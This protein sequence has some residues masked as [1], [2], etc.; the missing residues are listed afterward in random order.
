MNC[1][2]SA[3]LGVWAPLPS[4]Q[5]EFHYPSIFSTTTREILG[6]PASTSCP[7]VRDRLYWYS[8]WWI[9]LTQRAY[10]MNI[11]SQPCKIS[12]LGLCSF[13]LP[14][15]VPCR[16]ET[17]CRSIRHPSQADTL[18]PVARTWARFVARFL[19]DLSIME[20]S[21]RGRLTTLHR[22]YAAIEASY[23]PEAVRFYANA[24]PYRH[25][26]LAS[27]SLTDTSA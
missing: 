21:N 23:Q 2:S 3:T 13:G 19:L 5:P 26:T 17:G 18:V 7:T 16:S 25:L 6:R 11:A 24:E 10:W 15:F 9:G 22:Q 4:T 27:S 8:P 20:P 1:S 14:N 12:H